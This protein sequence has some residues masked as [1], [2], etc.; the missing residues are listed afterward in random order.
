MEQI[1]RSVR[2]TE[3]TLKLNKEA[4][5]FLESYRVRNIVSKYSRS[6]LPSDPYAEKS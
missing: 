6:Y 1:D 4:K 3:I 5:E 2:G